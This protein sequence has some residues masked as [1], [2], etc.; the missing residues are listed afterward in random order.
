MTC[1][2]GPLARTSLP[3]RRDGT[4]RPLDLTP[5]DARWFHSRASRRDTTAVA[6]YSGTP[7][8]KKLGIKEGS[9]VGLVGAHPAFAQALGELP[10]GAHF[11]PI[12]EGALDVVVCFSTNH[13]QL[14]ERFVELKPLLAYTGGLWIAWPKKMPGVPAGLVENEVRDIGLAAGLVDNKVC[15]IDDTWSGLR[16]VYRL[17]DRPG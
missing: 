14:A 12:E 2:S 11:V 6:G 8:P 9:R 10:A 1:G 4:P 15:A 16:F 13:A 17:K 3:G 7:L 5:A